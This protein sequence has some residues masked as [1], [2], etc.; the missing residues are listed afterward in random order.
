MTT[1][2]NVSAKSGTGVVLDNNDV[3]W[4][5]V[6]VVEVVHSVCGGV[7]CGCFPPL[8]QPLELELNVALSAALP[9]QHCNRG[10]V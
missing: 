2:H 3:S 1:V 10:M 5:V 7:F 4:D 8:S 9:G 6:D